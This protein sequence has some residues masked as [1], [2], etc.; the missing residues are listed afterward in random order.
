VTDFRI[1]VIID[2]GPATTGAKKVESQLKRTEGAADRLQRTLLRAFTL[3]GGTLLIRELGQIADAYTNVQNRLRTVTEGEQ[4]LAMATD[5]L[6]KI[7]NRTR[8]AFDAT[9]EV[10]ARVGLAAKNLG[11][12]Q[13]ELLAFTESLNQAVVLSGASSEEARAGLVQLS[14]GLA[15]GALRGDEL[16]SVLEQLPVVADVISKSLGITRGQLREL[17]AEGKITAEIVLDAFKE[18][19][20]ELDERFGKSVPTL[21]Q[22]FTVL[23]N[24]VVQYVGS[25]NEASGISSTLSSVILVLANNVQLLAAGMAVISAAAL[26]A[27]IRGFG[28][29][30]TQMALAQR[31]AASGALFNPIIAGAAAAGAATL[32]FVD[33]YEKSLDRAVR[34]TENLDK[35]FREAARGGDLGEI[36][37]A[38]ANIE[39]TLKRIQEAAAQGL[40]D[41]AD[42]EEKI[43]SLNARLDDLGQEWL[44]LSDG[45]GRTLAQIRAQNKAVDDLAKAV[46]SAA[47]RIRSEGEA[48]VITS[49]ELSARKRLLEELSKLQG[50]ATPEQE[51]ALKVAIA[52]AQALEDQAK[53]YDRIRGPQQEF[54]A[55]LTAIDALL[56]SGK[57]SRDEAKQAIVELTDSFNGLDFSKIKGPEGL[58]FQGQLKGIQEFLAAQ[59][60]AAKAEIERRQVI[61]SLKGPEEELLERKRIL[62]S[63]LGDESVNQERLAKALAEVESAL[64]PVSDAQ[65]RY[66]AL[67]EEIRGP[68][69]ERQQR[70]QDLNTLLAINIAT[71]GQAGITLAEY[72]AELAKLNDTA[73]KATDLPLADRIQQLTEQFRTGELTQQQYIDSLQRLEQFKGPSA[74][75]LAGLAELNA[76]LKA[77]TI[78]AEEFLTKFRE[79]GNKAENPVVTF[80]DG[81]SDAFAQLQEQAKTTGEITSDIL[82]GAFNKSADALAEFAT[83]GKLDFK[84][85]ASSI[86]SDIAR[87]LAQ[88]LLLKAL[89]I[90]APVPGVTGAASGGDFE[91]NKS[92]IVGEKGPELVNFGQGGSIT[93]ADQTKQALAASGAG[94]GGAPT[95]NVAPAQVNLQVVNVQSP[96]EAR[97]AMDTSEGG[98]VILNQVRS[99]RAAMRRELGIG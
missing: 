35:A 38:M 33:L 95:V 42:A 27:L 21:S 70:I 57:I 54:E 69:A 19:R 59:T 88:Q 53:A 1:R 6:F 36:D 41:P 18:A 40:I 55:G 84:E 44:A 32:F 80:S 61:E 47:E 93:P 72:N 96:D 64:N 23:R 48:L 3:V 76:E 5:E 50:K 94:G 8:S 22:S 99:N 4:E 73:Q 15:S 74:E 11:R 77:G 83:T 79:L 66:N 90:S 29:W 26:P 9:A 67:I 98:K 87:I 46:D 43:A 30:I 12:D 92:M 28:A 65:A 63:L 25:L 78:S 31:I 17:G 37:T 49:R 34:E 68:E 51:A 71:F 56:K 24:N 97:S 62:T 75:F 86:L 20:G 85:F 58:D 60:A 82:V 52:E 13:S 81:A 10:Y 89:G 16:R 91:P 45:S 2:P 7:A 39:R 14:Q